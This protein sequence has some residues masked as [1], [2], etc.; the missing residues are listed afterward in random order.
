MP[1]Y[2]FE[3]KECKKE[4]DEICSFDENNI[5]PSVICPYCGS[6]KKDKLI[7]NINFKFTNPIGTDRWNN[8]HDYRF[9][10]NIPNVKA[11]REA[12]ETLSHMG[13]SP[14]GKINSVE[15]DLNLGEGIHDPDT[16]S[17]LS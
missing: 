3:C 9:K 12:A 15:S 6:N 16:R 2:E 10:H 11:E 4:F 5:Y 13:T 17:G 8:S 1:L 7:S 14:Y